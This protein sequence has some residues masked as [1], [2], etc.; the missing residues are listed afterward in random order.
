V[1]IV[2]VKLEMELGDTMIYIE[3]KLLLQSGE[4]R[5]PVDQGVPCPGPGPGPPRVAYMLTAQIL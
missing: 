1:G 3:T 5:V 2:E 4:N